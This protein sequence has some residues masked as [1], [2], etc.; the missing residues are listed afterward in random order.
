MVYLVSVADLMYSA[1]LNY[2]AY[3]LYVAYLV[4]SVYLVYLI[5]LVYSA[6]LLFEIS[7]Q[8][9][10]APSF[11][12]N[13][14]RHTPFGRQGAHLIPLAAAQALPRVLQ[15]LALPCCHHSRRTAQTWA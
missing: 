14:L 15:S 13:L 9:G 4:Y 11:A 3:L 10:D 2:L 8:L 7:T 1:Y 6:D 5:Y 12:G